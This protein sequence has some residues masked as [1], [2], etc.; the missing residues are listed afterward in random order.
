MLGYKRVIGITALLGWLLL[1][2]CGTGGEGEGLR[3]LPARQRT[4]ECVLNVVKSEKH[5]LF[6]HEIRRFLTQSA[7][8]NELGR[9]IWHVCDIWLLT[10]ILNNYVLVSISRMDN[11][12]S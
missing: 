11:G 2:S 4:V 5:G 6:L 7:L 8:A 12:Q 1:G 3:A 10:V 9:R